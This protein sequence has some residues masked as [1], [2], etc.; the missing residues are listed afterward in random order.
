MHADQQIRVV[1]GLAAGLGFGYQHGDSQILVG[2][3]GILQ[4]LENPTAEELREIANS[5]SEAA[6]ELAPRLGQPGAA[7]QPVYPAVPPGIEDIEGKVLDRV[8]AAS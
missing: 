3:I 2:N 1:A 7:R 4:D 8:K 6:Q 5:S